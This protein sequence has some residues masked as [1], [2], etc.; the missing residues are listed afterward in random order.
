MLDLTREA[1]D[2]VRIVSRISAAG[3]G[4]GRDMLESGESRRAEGRMVALL[5]LAGR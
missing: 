1:S 5:V 2:D 3:G 4:A